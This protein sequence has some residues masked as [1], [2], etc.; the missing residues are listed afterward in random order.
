MLMGKHRFPY[1]TNPYAEA[2]LLL[3][4]GA[5]LSKN[6]TQSKDEFITVALRN[7]NRNLVNLLKSEFGG[8]R[9][10]I[11][12]LT[13]RPDLIGKTCVVEKHLP[14]KGRYKVIFEASKEVGLVGPENLVRRDRTPDD[15]GY[16]INYKNGR[17]ARHDFESKEECQAFVA[18]LT[19]E[20]K[21]GDGD[22][23]AEAEARAE[24][25]AESLLAE[26]EIDSSMD[27]DRMSKKKKG[28]QNGKKKGKGRK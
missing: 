6:A 12:N 5:D 1:A 10:K 26:L 27:S 14:D 23:G 13:K 22:D 20:N 15:C 8:R 2:K 25:A 16:F 24:E 19:E 18:S 11:I 21:S 17:T 3:E 28:K 7:D 4:W 9:C